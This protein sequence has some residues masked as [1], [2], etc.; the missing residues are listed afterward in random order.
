MLDL[1]FMLR[2]WPELLRGLGTTL[3]YTLLSCMAG[4]VIG[5]IV[6]Q[7]QIKNVPV[8]RQI[9]RIQIE[10]FRNLPL[11]VVLLWSYYALPIYLGIDVSKE[12]AGLVALS[13][14]AG[15]FYGEILRGSVQSIDKSQAEM[16]SVLGLS[17][18]QTEV[19]VIYPQAFRSALPAL[20]GQT[21]M[22]MKNTTLLSVIAV[23]ELAYYGSHLSS[24]T[25]R[26]ME[27]YTLV[28]LIFLA[29][30]VPMN[31]LSRWI[32]RRFLTWSAR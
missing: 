4:L 27:I 14:Y 21:I 2:I 3:L 12:A 15:A 32:E 10:V 31:S 9:A 18:L 6:A 7:S 29:V 26:P 30:L 8:L 23:A 20:M 22:N 25:F 28:G 13:L 11:L 5:V 17:R 19:Y 16:S 1:N 24:T